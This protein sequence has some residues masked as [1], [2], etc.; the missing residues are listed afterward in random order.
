MHD[1]C[2]RR[3]CCDVLLLMKYQNT[4]SFCSCWLIFNFFFF[5]FFAGG[6]VNIFVD[7]PS[8]NIDHH[9]GS[10]FRGQVKDLIPFLSSLGLDCPSYHN[11]ADFMME[12]ATGE[13]GRHHERMVEA[14]ADPRWCGEEV[15]K[16]PSSE[17]S[18]KEPTP[19]PENKKATTTTEARLTADGDVAIEM[20]TEKKKKKTKTEEKEGGGGGS[21]DEEC[22]Q[23]LLGGSMES[24]DTKSGGSFPTS[25]WTQF[26]I[27]FLRTFKSII[28][29]H[30]LTNLRLMS[31]VVVGL[32]LGNL[33]WN[34]GNEASKVY[35]NSAMLFFCMLFSMFAAMMP[36]VMTFPLE[37][38]TFKRE[39]LNYW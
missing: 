16:A 17:P 34:M 22:S 5:F 9:P 19:E 38:T 29:D 27:L 13:Y 32:L 25:T 37:M 24:V 1:G 2:C 18:S 10:F 31:H 14:V 33:Y 15:R 3:C 26:R 12:V 11:P 7:T 23:S 30:T 36:T 35:N 6:L 20:P 28:R 8:A 4:F 39:H 21:S